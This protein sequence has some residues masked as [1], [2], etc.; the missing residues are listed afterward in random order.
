MSDYSELTPKQVE[1]AMTGCLV[2]SAVILIAV[3][4][5]Y[6]LHPGVGFLAVGIFV[7]A[8][9]KVIREAQKKKEAEPTL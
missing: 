6:L 7:Y 2:I 9:A 8:W 4:L 3:G 5:G 1:K